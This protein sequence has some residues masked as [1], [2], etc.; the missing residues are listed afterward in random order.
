M[1]RFLIHPT[2]QN[3]SHPDYKK[4]LIYTWAMCTIGAFLIPYFIYFWVAYPE[5]TIKNSTNLIFGG[6]FIAG[7]YLG[8]YVQ[9]IIYII[10]FIALISYP[11]IMISIYHTGGIYS[12]EVVWIFVCLISQTIFIDYRV[13]IIGG[14]F[15]IIFYTYLF[16]IEHAIPEKEAR[17]K[18]YILSHSNIN[19][20]L[21]LTFVTVLILS[22]LI[23]FARSLTAANKKIEELSKDKIQSLE[24]MLEE[25][26]TELSLIRQSLAKDFHDEMGNKLASISILSQAIAL[27]NVDSNATPETKEM[28]HSINIH[29]KELY[30][31]TKDFIW[32]IDFKHDYVLELYIYL[33]EFGESFFS[34]IN[35]NFLSECSIPEETIMR[36]DP[37][38]GRQVLFICKEIM[39]NA[40]K[41][42]TCDEVKLQLAFIEGFIVLRITD[43][44]CGF[45]LIQVQK[46]GLNNMLR[47]SEKYKI[48]LDIDTNKQGSV[49][50]LKIPLPTQMW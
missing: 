48:G 25:K 6:L 36:I 30:E 45:D 19:N 50:T 4:A 31:G 27:Q 20:F 33:R 38:V 16:Y 26:T 13:G 21:T 17:Y 32:S 42:A 49:F 3:P 23:T 34:K 9:K 24:N 15:S 41:H 28:L 37:I 8:R 35:I 12:V 29:A 18:E 2:L 40:A 46:R 11:P 7:I 44:G 39:T 43:N 47:R 14:I 1:L 5:D 10:G 22:L